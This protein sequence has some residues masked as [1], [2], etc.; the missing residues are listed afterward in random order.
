M[1]EGTTLCIERCALCVDGELF[2]ILTTGA[3]Y[4]GACITMNGESF[5]AIATLDLRHFGA[6]TLR[7]RPGLLP[8]D[9]DEKT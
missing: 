8:R 6:V 4:D 7:G 9:L 1:Q 2:S 3:E 5:D